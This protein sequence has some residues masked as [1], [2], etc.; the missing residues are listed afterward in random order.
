MY[1]SATLRLLFSTKSIDHYKLRAAPRG[2]PYILA[3]G[4]KKR[5]SCMNKS[6][7]P[8]LFIANVILHRKREC[9]TQTDRLATAEEVAIHRLEVEGIEVGIG[10]VAAPQ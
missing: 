8:S 10:K 3:Q 9:S 7:Q 2:G 6:Q 5:E 1:G 4:N